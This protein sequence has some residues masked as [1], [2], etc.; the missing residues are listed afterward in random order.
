MSRPTRPVPSAAKVRQKATT[1]P[2]WFMICAIGAVVVFA[3][4][5][6]LALTQTSSTTTAVW[7]ADVDVTGKL[8]MAPA[9]GTDPAVG[10]KSPTATGQDFAG[11][12][13]TIPVAGEPTIMVFLAHWCSHC[14]AEVPRIVEYAAANPL[15]EGTNIVGVSTLASPGRP[16]F[17]PAEWLEREAWPFDVLVDSKTTPVWNAFGGTGTPFTVIVDAN[18]TVVQRFV[19]GVDP[20]LLWSALAALAA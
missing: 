13:V 12:P 1:R 4:V 9:S 3:G 14:Q 16:N 8:A 17:G 18:G 6:A 19:G 11:Q 5:L 10:E 2:P 15:P 20:Q 7:E